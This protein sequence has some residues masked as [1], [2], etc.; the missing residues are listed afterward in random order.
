MAP[1]LFGKPIDGIRGRAELD[2]GLDQGL[3]LLPGHRPRDFISPL[4]EQFRG[5]SD[6]LVTV[7]RGSVPPHLETPVSRFKRVIKVGPGGM[8]QSANLLLGRGINDRR[9]PTLGPLTSLA[10]YE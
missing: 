7:E 6:E 1:A 3:S 9:C 8:G 4:A 5:G 10:V 2:L